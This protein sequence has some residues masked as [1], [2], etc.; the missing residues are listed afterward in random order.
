MAQ[1]KELSRQEWTEAAEEAKRDFIEALRRG[2]V[3]EW[4]RE[5]FE[6][7][8]LE[9]LLKEELYDD[10]YRILSAQPVQ[11]IDRAARGSGGWT[12]PEGDAPFFNDPRNEHAVQYYRDGL[13]IEAMREA[14][15]RLNPRTADVWR[16]LTA[17]S[18]EFWQE[19]QFE[20]P[21]V[22]IDVRQLLQVMGYTKHHKGGFKPEQVREVAQAVGDLDNFYITIPLG[23]QQYPEDKKRPGRRKKVKLEATRSYKVLF[24]AATDEVKDLFGNR[25]PMR[26]LLRPGEWIKAYPRQF[27]P[28]YR[29]IVELPAKA[30]PHTWAKAIGTELSYQY[31]QDRDRGELKKL[32]VRTLLERACLLEETLET[33]K[34]GRMRGY[35]EGAMD[36]LRE[37]GVCQ[38]WEYESGGIDQVEAVSKGWFDRWLEVSVVVTAPLYVRALPKPKRFE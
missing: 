5:F 29:A 37:I 30:G 6:K 18:L 36:I 34:K 24:N 10:L 8:L 19:G 7:S 28:I 17:A 14:V 27:A 2:E 16:L 3:P 20:P 1:A 25:Y 4:V 21:A 22:W 26:W 13:T 23:T 33:K 31:R 38:A 9:N 15:L 12:F 11:T 35:F 32:K